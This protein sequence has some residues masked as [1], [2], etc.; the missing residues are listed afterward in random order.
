MVWMHR[1][2]LLVQVRW[3]ALMQ[4]L[5][6]QDLLHGSWT[7]PNKCRGVVCHTYCTGLDRFRGVQSH[8]CCKN[9]GIHRSVSYG[10]SRTLASRSQSE[11]EVKMEMTILQTLLAVFLLLAQIAGA[12]VFQHQQEVGVWCSYPNWGT[13]RKRGECRL[14]R[15]KVTC[16]ECRVV[17]QV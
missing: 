17:W 6:M 7:A 12:Q 14:K 15:R 9:L 5:A 8:R 2:A 11:L 1:S 13:Q 4:F 3:L 10:T 16:A